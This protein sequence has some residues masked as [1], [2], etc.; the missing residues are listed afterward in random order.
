[1]HYNY[2]ATSIIDIPNNA[3]PT[4]NWLGPLAT[5]MLK[6]ALDYRFSD[7]IISFLT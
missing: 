1:L 2:S 5:G 6:K 3:I 4:L 7:F